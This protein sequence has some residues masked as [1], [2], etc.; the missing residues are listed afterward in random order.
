MPG[1][2]VPV[3]PVDEWR[4]PYVDGRNGIFY[5]NTLQ[6]TPVGESSCILGCTGVRGNYIRGGFFLRID[7]LVTFAKAVIEQFGK[8]TTHA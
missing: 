7:D 2:T 3:H 4:K 1:L 6:V 8:E 5:I